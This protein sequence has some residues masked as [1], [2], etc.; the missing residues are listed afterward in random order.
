[1]GTAIT[2]QSNA[3]AAAPVMKG[4]WMFSDEAKYLTPTKAQALKDKGIT[5]VFV[6]TRDGGGTWYYKSLQNAITQYYEIR[7]GKRVNTDIS[8]V[9]FS[10][11]DREEDE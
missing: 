1:M 6:C 2:E 5:D 10:L 7:E 3:Y 4:Y 8:V 11:I 9:D